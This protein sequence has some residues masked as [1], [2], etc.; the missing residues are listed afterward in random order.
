MLTQVPPLPDSPYPGIK[1]FRFLDQQIFSSRDEETWNL[2]SNILIYRGVL[3][4][5]DSGSGK[6][7]LIN[8][9]LIPAALKENF[10]A[11]RLR[12]QPQ[13][14]KEI[15]IE[16]IPIELEDRPPYLP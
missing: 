1:S 14:G 10:I 7:S 5:G 3:L 2:L 15:K 12:V 6:S 8:A 11:H 4:Y 9:G 16:R 13:L